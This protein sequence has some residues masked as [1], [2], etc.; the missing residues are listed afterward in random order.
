MPTQNLL[1]LET[2]PYLRQHATNPVHWAPWG[3]A[4]LDE[5]RERGLP[6]LLSIGYA[7]CHWCHVMAHESFE[8]PESAAIMNELF[9]CIK[10]DREERPDI[11]DIYMTALSMLGEQGGWPLT[12][13]LDADARPFWGGTYFPKQAGYGR[14]AFTQVLEQI[15]AA[16]QDK[17]EQVSKNATAI[18]DG[19]RARAKA[20]A[21]AQ[22]PQDLAPRAMRSLAAH[23]DLETGG[24]GG[25]PQFPQPSLYEFIWQQAYL[26]DDEAARDAVLFTFLQICRGGIYDHLGGGFARYTVDPNWLIPHFE[27]MLYDNAQIICVLTQLWKYT[28]NP[29]FAARIRETIDW[30]MREMQTKEKAFISSYDADSE[31]E[32]GKF[33]VW[34]EDEIHHAFHKSSIS[35]LGYDSFAKAYG[36]THAGNF[37][38]KNIL[39]RLD[40]PTTKAR[41]LGAASETDYAEEI[42]HKAAR[43]VL[44][45]TRSERITPAADDK[46]LADWNGMTIAAL[47]QAGSTFSMP[48]WI[49]FAQEAFSGIEL[50]LADGPTLRHSACAGTTMDIALGEDYAHMALAAV[51]LFQSTQETRYLSKALTWLD[52]LEA[53]YLDETGIGFCSSPKNQPD[54]LVRNRPIFD[55]AVPGLNGSIVQLYSKLACLTGNDALYKKAAHLRD[56]FSGHLHKNYIQMPGFLKS[57]S[58]LDHQILVVLT[59]PIDHLMISCLATHPAPHINWLV[60]SDAAAPSHSNHLD[61]SHPAY[62]KEAIDGRPT[63]YVCFAQTCLA[64]ITDTDKLRATLDEITVKT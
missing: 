16:Y 56:A 28:H 10:V 20:D 64:P 29:I 35:T 63:A 11:D 19:L 59:G 53:D 61:E 27:K 51:S 15:S 52:Q 24:I 43:E 33:Y 25:A 45:A 1:Y 49:E 26:N 46:V 57:A 17:S 32:E 41:D 37:E 40:T 31:G 13:F 62:G 39:N 9:V 5:A 50:L 48:D 3:Q 12:M 8:D 22:F 36:V 21:N 47:S 18:T 42:L 30:L 6:I 38:G 7:A 55:N 14:P 60:K 4:A 44:F 34:S 23:I 58:L 54:I 2:S